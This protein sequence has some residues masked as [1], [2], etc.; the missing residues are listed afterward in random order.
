MK[1]KS[2]ISKC[3]AV[4]FALTLSSSVLASDFCDGFVEGYK[5]LAGNSAFVPM[6]PFE[7]LTPFNSTPFREGMKAGIAAARRDGH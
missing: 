6:C 7:P 4:F 2:F 3:I 1:T 5:S